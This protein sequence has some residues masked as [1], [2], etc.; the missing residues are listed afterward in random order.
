MTIIIFIAVIVVLILIHELGH[1]LVAKRA[2]ARVDEF[3]IGFPPRIISKQKGETKYSLGIIPL[4]GFVKIFGENSEEGA[5]KSPRSLENLSRR[6][7]AA[8]MFAGVFFNILFAWVVFSVIPIFGMSVPSDYKSPFGEKIEGKT[9]I[10]E[11]LEESP[12][13]KAGL[14]EGDAIISATA[15][16][17]KIKSPI[18]ENLNNFVEAHSNSSIEITYERDG[19]IEN[20]LIK[21]TKNIEGFEDKAIIGIGIYE[22]SILKTSVLTAP[23]EGAYLTITTTTGIIYAFFDL[24]KDAI[25]GNASLQNVSGPVGIFEYTSEAFE[26]GVKT[27]LLFV[28]LISINLAIIN[29]LPLPALDGGRLLVLGIEGVIRRRVN[30]NI[31][32]WINT[33]GFFLLIVLMIVVTINDIFSLTI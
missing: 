13:E 22:E 31:V 5:E 21:P 24:I 30:P 11:T 33:I 27:L 19:E 29:L 12:A 16:S 6:S 28:A 26:I 14:Q 25:L 18:S 32:N 1:F 10:I 4:G 8:I 9:I 17:D 20:A 23:L 7:Q 15:E 2:G 3:C